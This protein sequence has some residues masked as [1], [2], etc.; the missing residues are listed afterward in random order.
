MTDYRRR[1]IARPEIGGVAETQTGGDLDT[2]SVA[3]ETSAPASIPVVASPAFEQAHGLTVEVEGQIGLPMNEVE[4]ALGEPEP[5]AIPDPTP[6]FPDEDTSAASVLGPPRDLGPLTSWYSSILATQDPTDDHDRYSR[7]V[8]ADEPQFMYLAGTAGTGKTYVGRLRATNYDDALLCAT[9]GIAAVNLGGT[10]INSILRYYDTASMQTEYEFGRL[11]VALKQIAGSGFRRLIID[12]VSMMDGKQLD[13]LMLA[14]DEVNEWLVGQHERPLGITLVGDFA[15]LPPV[16]APFVFERESWQRF[17]PNTLMLTEPRRQ[18]D[19]E[20]VRAL[21]AVRRG[22]PAA[23]DYFR[24]FMQPA[25]IPNFDGSSILAK[26]D[27]VDRMNKLRLL[28]L[29]G[30]VIP[31]AAVK[32]GKAAPEWK[33]IPDVLELKPEALVM[34]LANA[35]DRTDPQNPELIYANGDLGHF[36][37][38]FREN[39]PTSPAYVRLHRTGTEVLVQRVV[40]ENTKATGNKGKKAKREDVEG[41]ISYLPLRVAYGTTVHKSQGLSLDNVQLMINSQFWMTSGMLYVALSRARTPQGLKIVGTADQFRAR[42]R[43]NPKIS[44]WL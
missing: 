44:R 31:F 38:P 28:N 34:I 17:E 3:D 37:R 13:V 5:A 6:Q 18:A 33:H 10:T 12:E 11:N 22:D 8:P 23:T 2:T 7:P 36:T 1:V 27:E 21:Q 14:V 4:I 9:T 42:I 26:N 15:Q 19:P 16:K 43:S 40:R 41:T 30:A 35:Y 24:P 25:A 20:F 32:T 29:P 39:D